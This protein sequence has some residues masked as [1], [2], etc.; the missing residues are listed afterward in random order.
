VETDGLRRVSLGVPVEAASLID[1]ALAAH[2]QAVTLNLDG[3]GGCSLHGLVDGAFDAAALGVDLALAAAAAGIEPPAVTIETL[4]ARNWLLENR[5]AFAPFRLGRF[6]IHGHDDRSPPP[7]ATWPIAVDAGLAFGTGR[8]ASTAGC[9]LALQR[10]AL[11]PIAGPVL[12]LGCGTGILA[13]AAAR[14]LGRPVVAAD[15]DPVAVRITAEN[16][17]RNGVADRVRAVTADGCAQLA[18][19]ARAPY[20][21]VFANIL[22]RPLLRL[23]RDIVAETAPGGTIIL[24]GFISDDAR[25][26]LSAYRPLGCRLARR[27]AV[28][29][30]TTL[31]LRR[32]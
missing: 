2:C 5:Q 9:L 19:R 7:P 28:D 20:A 13:I 12:D 26:V 4:A 14:V 16:A 6:F 29:G 1:E 21:L 17:A 3:A 10:A 32:R 23:A 8:H 22:A 30:W 27:I 24:A 15:I 31:V 25:R 18:V 11:S